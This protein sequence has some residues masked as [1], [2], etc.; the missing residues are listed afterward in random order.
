MQTLV[1]F[2]G[3]FDPVHRGHLAVIEA[4]MKMDPAA[5]IVVIPA[6]Q[7]P[8]KEHATLN[9]SQRLIALIRATQ[10]LKGIIISDFEL[11]RTP[12]NYT[13]D[14]IHH[15]KQCYS[16]Q[17]V[18]IVMGTDQLMQL[19]KWKDSDELLKIAHVWVAPRNG[20]LESEIRAKWATLSDHPD[21]CKIL[22]MEEYHQSATQLKATDSI[23][24]LRRSL[25]RVIGVT[26]RAGSG[27]STASKI[28][29]T[30]LNAQL[31]DLDKMGHK[32]LTVRYIQQ[33]IVDRYGAELMCDGEINRRILG[34]IVFNDSSERQWLDQ[35]M[36]PIMK[37]DVYD[38]IAKSHS[39]T[40]ILD[41]AL[42]RKIGLR[43]ICGPLICIDATDEVILNNAG[44]GKLAI[45]NVQD[46]RTV[47]ADDADILIPNNNDITEL[48]LNLQNLMDKDMVY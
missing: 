6:G 21:R 37:Q 39:N 14:T 47:F 38:I 10:H 25:P 34:K 2:G 32:L 29:L 3:S 20:V 9:R 16:P 5:R 46:S 26:G 27:K 18:A 43:S 15:L 8:L 40:I 23:T 19:E 48:T 35:L 28:L 42:I 30:A 13:I 33:K 11:L 41:G 24:E 22:S 4:A 7:S 12:P 17:S 44:E 45:A 1:L 31:I 36:H